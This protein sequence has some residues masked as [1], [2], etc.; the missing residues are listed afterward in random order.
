MK[1]VVDIDD[2]LYDMWKVACECGMGDSATRMILKGTPLKDILN[3]LKVEIDTLSG[4][5]VYGTFA[6]DRIIHILDIVDRYI[7]ESK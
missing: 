3:D 2:E 6:Y 1:I 4:T 7:K 5:C